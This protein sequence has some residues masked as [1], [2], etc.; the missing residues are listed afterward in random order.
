VVIIVIP[1]T[2]VEGLDTITLESHDSCEIFWASSVEEEVSLSGVEYWSIWLLV[3]EIGSSC[4]G[5][6]AIIVSLLDDMC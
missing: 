5:N 4:K 1:L 2:S 6:E 3:M